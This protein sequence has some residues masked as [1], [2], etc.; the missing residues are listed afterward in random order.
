MI[1]AS[2]VVVQTTFANSDTSCYVYVSSQIVYRVHWK[3]LQ[4]GIKQRSLIA[5]TEYL[6]VIIPPKLNLATIPPNE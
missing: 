6:P 2:L 3:Y 4:A 1:V 5:T